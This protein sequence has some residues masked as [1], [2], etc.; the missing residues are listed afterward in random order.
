[1][2]ENV[3]MDTMASYTP[4]QTTNHDFSELMSLALD[5]M[6]SAEEERRLDQHLQACPA[7][8][9]SWNRWQRV[10][11]FL[12]V[13]PFVGPPQGFALRLD[14]AL[15]RDE[16]RQEHILASLLLAGGTA[17]VLA[18]IVLGAALTTGLWMAISPLERVQLVETMGFAGQFM[19]LV[20]QN[21]VAIRNGIAAMIPDPLIMLVICLALITASAV[22]VRLVFFG[23]GARPTSR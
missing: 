12:T 20:F 15:Q 6:L 21:L 9:S 1:M 5:G 17:T 23:N 7:C 10:S 19:A 2:K 16:R 14:H 18:L 4:N 11:H 22:W 3:C 8:Q 13:E